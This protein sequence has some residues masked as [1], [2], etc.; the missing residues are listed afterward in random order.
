VPNPVETCSP[1]IEDAWEGGAERRV[2]SQRQMGG[3][4]G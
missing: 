2:P 4:M 1:R 3:G